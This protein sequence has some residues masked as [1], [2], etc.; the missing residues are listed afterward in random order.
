VWDGDG[1]SLTGLHADHVVSKPTVW[2][3][4]NMELL[5]WFLNCSNCS[6]PTGWDG[7]RFF[8]S[9]A[10]LYMASS[11]PTAWDSNWHSYF[12]NAPCEVEN[13]ELKEKGLNF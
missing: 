6:E 11:K 8:K 13:V 7:N 1:N 3:G 9:K 10:T 4:D 5:Y 2:D 12:P